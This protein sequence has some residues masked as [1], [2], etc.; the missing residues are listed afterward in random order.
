[1]IDDSKLQVPGEFDV[2][3]YDIR[4][5]VGDWR[6]ADYGDPDDERIAQLREEFALDDVV[7]GYGSEFEA[8]LALRRWVRSRWDHGWSHSFETVEDA[9]DILQEAQRGEQFTCGFYATVFVACA[10]ALGWPAR[11]ISI[12]LADCSFPRDRRVGNV[13]HSV[14]EAWSNE[15]EKW[16][17]LDPDLN[18]HYERDGVPLSALEIREAWFT[19]EADAV[20]MVQDQP[21]FVV[22][23]GRTVE[24]LNEIFPEYG[25]SDDN[26]AA[27]YCERFTRNRAMDYYGRVRINGW[28]WVDEW[29]LPTFVR[30][31]EPAGRAR[32]TSHLPDM[33]WSLNTVRMTA[34]PSWDED[35]AALE[36]ALEHCAPWFDHYEAR[37]DGGGWE[38][39]DGSFDWPMR[40]GVNVLEC[41]TVNRRE[42]PGIAS[43][44]EVAYARPRW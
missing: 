5:F 7:A 3:S 27:A 36:I 24:L 18:V 6:Q 28:E 43:R 13:G 12:G 25:I 30:H 39:R 17:V 41:R 19:G 40:E 2:I 31:F 4:D 33:Y 21:A 23:S 16:V 37:V 42:R 10:T 44:L 9:L 38:R 34:R 35:G 15:H 26:R 1:M 14:P 8:L 11:K 29:C 32:F 20:E 22:P